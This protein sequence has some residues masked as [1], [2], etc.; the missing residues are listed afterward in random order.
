MVRN[1]LNATMDVQSHE[2]RQED[3]VEFLQSVFMHD[4]EDLRAKDSWKVLLVSRDA[5]VHVRIT[6]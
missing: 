4:F 2:E 1:G 5:V 6:D 3:E